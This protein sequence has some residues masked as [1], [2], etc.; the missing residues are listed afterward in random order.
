MLIYTKYKSQ[1]NAQDLYLE[2]DP[3][4][5]FDSGVFIESNAEIG[6]SVP[7]RIFHRRALR[8][9]FQPEICSRDEAAGFISDNTDLINSLIASY[10]EGWDGNNFVGKWDES[11]IE[12]LQESCDGFE[13]E[14][15]L[16]EAADWLWEDQDVILGKLET[17]K[18]VEEIEAELVAEARKDKV[19]LYNLDG[20]LD[21]L[22]T[23]MEKGE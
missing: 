18:S 22:L 15:S 7:S 19:E 14:W 4:L 11:L 17:E 10:D 2:I 6:G 5:D 3:E 9:K 8:F 16:C 13:T 20:F 21:Y 1:V 12:K 23:Q